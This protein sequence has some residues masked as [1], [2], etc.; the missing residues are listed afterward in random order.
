MN[1]I[2]TAVIK[3]VCKNEAVLT[4]NKKLKG[5]KDGKQVLWCNTRI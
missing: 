1:K 4:D 3:V 2:E 5:E